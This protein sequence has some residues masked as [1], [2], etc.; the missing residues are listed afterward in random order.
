MFCFMHLKHYSEG[1][2]T[3]YIRLP[4]SSTVPNG[5]QAPTKVSDTEDYTS[6]EASATK[7]LSQSLCNPYF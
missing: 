7:V 1:G 6:Q 3:G 4:K 5:W 2:S